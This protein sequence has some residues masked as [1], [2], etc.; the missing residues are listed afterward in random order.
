LTPRERYAALAPV[1]EWLV[2]DSL[3]TPEDSVG[4]FA[5]V[6]EE[7]DQGARVLDCA[8]GI[9][10]LAVGLRLNGFEVIATDASTAMV[11]RTRRL[12]RD[13]GV[14]LQTAVCSWNELLEQGTEQLYLYGDS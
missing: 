5:E 4:A 12:A 7:L 2:P 11:E 3:L 14:G 10:Q 6:I 13:H 8:A 1:Y 9:G